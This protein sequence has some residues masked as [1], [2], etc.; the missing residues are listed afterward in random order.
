MIDDWRS[1]LIERL[2]V[3]HKLSQA[4]RRIAGGFQHIGNEKTGFWEASS[5]ARF[6]IETTRFGV[7]NSH[8]FTILACFY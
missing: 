5:Q 3:N 6:R 8:G 7:S 4:G 2:T 1:L